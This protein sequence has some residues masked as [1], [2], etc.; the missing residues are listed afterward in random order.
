M[1]DKKTR[2]STDE[3]IRIII[4]TFNPQ[5]SMAE[6]C[7]QHNLLPRTV[8]SWKEKFVAGG[9][10]SLDGSGTVRQARRHKKEVESLKRLVGEYAV[11]NAALKKTLEGEA[12]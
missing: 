2:L 8:Y 6:L 3:K 7:R 9:R 4:Q 12:E 11:A 5:T 1:T 10:I